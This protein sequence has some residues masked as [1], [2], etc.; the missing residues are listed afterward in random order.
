REV[1]ARTREIAAT[2]SEQV[3]ATSQSASDV[4]LIAQEIGILRR[5]N[6]EQAGIVSS[7][8][9]ALGGGGGSEGNGSAMEGPLESS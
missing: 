5:A 2:F 4:A 9:V 1:R 8:G 3:K 6:V 7:L